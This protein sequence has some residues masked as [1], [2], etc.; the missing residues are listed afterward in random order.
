LSAAA[1]PQSFSHSLILTREDKKHLKECI[2]NLYS[3]VIFNGLSLLVKYVEL[4]SS[5]SIDEVRYDLGETIK[6]L[7]REFSLFG[8]LFRLYKGF[9]CSCTKTAN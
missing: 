7:K 3:T 2:Q 5:S 6:E 1:T 8:Y 9:D 4:K